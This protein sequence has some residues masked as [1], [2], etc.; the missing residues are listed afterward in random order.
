MAYVKKMLSKD[1]SS[2]MNALQKKAMLSWNL[3]MKFRLRYSS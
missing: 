3:P 2:Q 1:I